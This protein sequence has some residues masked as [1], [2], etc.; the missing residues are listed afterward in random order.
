M[1]YTYFDIP[2]NE[3]IKKECF[4]EG[5]FLRYYDN[6]VEDFGVQNYFI[7]YDKVDKKCKDILKSIEKRVVKTTRSAI[8]N[9]ITF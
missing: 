8:S 1:K 9:T 2:V 3:D 7:P 4:T 5:R 6:F